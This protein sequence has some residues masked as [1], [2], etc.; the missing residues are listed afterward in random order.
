MKLFYRK[1]GEGAPLVLLHG[2]FGMSDNWVTIGKKLAEKFEVFIPDQRNHGQSPHSNTFNYF[3]LT[4]DLYEFI[5]DHGLRNIMLI[6]H[7][8]GGKV[9]MNYAFQ[10]PHR[11]E[12]VVIID[13]SL[14]KYPFRQ[15]HVEILKAM[16]SLDF[17]TVTHRKE[18]GGIL[19]EKIKPDAI[20]Q[21]ILKNIYR[22]SGNRLAW[23][24]NVKAVYD[25]L[26][27]IF[28]GVEHSNPFKKPVLFVRGGKSNY[29]S[30][31]D[32]DLIGA[33]FPGAI[34]KTLENASHWVHA[35]APDELCAVLSDFLEKECLYRPG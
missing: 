9:A 8:M 13:I 10:N 2:L 3:A 24:L 23:R 18:A 34:I 17:N 31:E 28:E 11:I 35:E 15:Q 26:E 1:Y 5:E 21:V 4:D 16:Q 6:G 25:N 33:A 32:T 29:I 22:I 20:V 14:R 12:K 19:S 7:S 30:D 27:Y